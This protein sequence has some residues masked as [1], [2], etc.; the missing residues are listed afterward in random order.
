[1]APITSEDS[2]PHMNARLIDAKKWDGKQMG[3]QPFTQSGRY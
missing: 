2:S 3:W 1:M